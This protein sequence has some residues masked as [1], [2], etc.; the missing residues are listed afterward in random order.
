M[1]NTD[2]EAKNDSTDTTLMVYVFC[3]NLTSSICPAF[4]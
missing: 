2:I 3:G 4:S 1:Q